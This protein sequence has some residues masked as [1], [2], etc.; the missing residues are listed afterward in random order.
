MRITHRTLVRSGLRDMQAATQRLGTYQEKI[1][2]TKRIRYPSDD[3]FAV[4][5]ALSFRAEIQALE[6]CQR[7]ME[8]SRDWLS[9]TDVA[10]DKMV[11]AM[12][13]ARSVGLRGA[14]DSVGAQAREAL[15]NEAS[16]LLG[17][18]IQAANT[19]SQGRYLFAGYKIRD[20]PFVGL[21]DN[22]VETF[23][24][25]EI[26]SVQYNGDGGSMV[27]ELEPGV[28]MVI[29]INGEETWL[30]PSDS[31]SVF[32]T[33]IDLRDSLL[34]GDSSAIRDA[35]D[36]LDDAI[37]M[38]GQSRAVVGARLQRLDLASR[39]LESVMLGAK[40]LLSKTEDVDMAEALVNYAQ[41][42]AVYKAALNVN[43][44]TLPI[45]LLDYLR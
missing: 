17:S 30:D 39:K 19:V 20:V 9:A 12:V 32:A 16:E 38:A 18:I 26:A 33:L 27:R 7:N 13:R 15:A 23:E 45:S 40:D 21:D 36:R 34:A 44:R 6:G 28:T 31:S 22:G 42:Q 25:S 8:L 14:D 3:P 43:A 2:S 24:S 11:D 35:L 29:N 4:G 37:S 1:S 10:L 5:R 41:E